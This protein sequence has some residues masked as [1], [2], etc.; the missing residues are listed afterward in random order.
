MNQYEAMFLFDPTFGSSLGKCEAE[1]RR[2]I[3]R[4]QGDIILCRKWDERRLAYRINGRSRGVYVLVY[5]TAPP[6]K[7]APLERDAK[8]SEPILRVLVVQAD[9]LTRESMEQA[10]PTPAETPAKTDTRGERPPEPT[11][12]SKET[13]EAEA[14]AEAVAASGLE[15]VPAETT[16]ADSP[17]EEAAETQ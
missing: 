14:K 6:E 10:F 3:E 15:P 13:G 11:T 5:F 8:L 12:V 17:P 16:M 2:L 9:A 4:A 7:I 1:I